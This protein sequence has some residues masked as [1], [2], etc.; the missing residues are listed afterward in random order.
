MNSVY[1]SRLIVPVSVVVICFGQGCV[2]K[3]KY[4]TAVEERDDYVG[5]TGMLEDRVAELEQD[6]EALEAGV[7]ALEMETRDLRAKVATLGSENAEL[8]EMVQELGFEKQNLGAE[9]A[10]QKREA[11]QFESTYDALVRDLRQEVA[12]GQIEVEQLRDGLKVNIAQEI[13]FGSG[14][15]MLDA[16]GKKILVKV[17]EQ[18][19]MVP[20][21]VVVAG[22]TDSNQIRG[23]LAELYPTNWEL[24]GARA[25]SVVRLFQ[26][27]GIEGSRLISV[28]R[29]EFQPVAPNDTPEDQA[30]NRRI[31]IRLRPVMPGD[32]ASAAG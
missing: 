5:K 23:R 31:E 25:A 4:L 10:R 18:L 24:G 1:W 9:L 20:Y 29:G 32:S 7:A 30:R 2:S 11:E 16:D 12:A 3:G 21:Q 6:K 13:L 22:H 14:S 15:A 26:E 17:C 8:D 27:E 19:K 28:S